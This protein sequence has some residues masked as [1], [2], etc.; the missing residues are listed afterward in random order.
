MCFMIVS[1]DDF[2]VWHYF[3]FM[4]SEGHCPGLVK[5]Y[6]KLCRQYPKKHF[7]IMTSALLDTKSGMWYNTYIDNQFH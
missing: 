6:K 3:Y 7:V 5:D 2:H 4:S 1:L